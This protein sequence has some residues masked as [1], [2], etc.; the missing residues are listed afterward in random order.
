MEIH[1]R[2]P[3]HCF[4]KANFVWDILWCGSVFNG[5]LFAREMYD[6]I[7]LRDPLARTHR[8]RVIL[9]YTWSKLSHYCRQH[10]IRNIVIPKLYSVEF[11][12]NCRFR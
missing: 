5:E 10:I 4:P 3:L 2:K 12:G 11:Q 1:I 6:T 7:Q 9:Y 8:M